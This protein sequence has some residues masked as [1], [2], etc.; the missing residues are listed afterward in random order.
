MASLVAIICTYVCMYEYTYENKYVRTYV[1][2]FLAPRDSYAPHTLLVPFGLA[3]RRS[4][5]KYMYTYIDFCKW[6]K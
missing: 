1:H 4:E 6:A 5:Y 3:F 2:F